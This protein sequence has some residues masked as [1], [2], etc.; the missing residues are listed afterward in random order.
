MK[1]VTSLPSSREILALAFRHRWS[2]ILAF[3][4]PV[5]VGLL[6]PRHLTPK[7]EARAQVLVKPGREFMPQTDTP[8]VSQLPQITMREMVDTVTQILQ[9]ADLIRDVLRDETVGKL[10]PQL[11]E[12]L[13][14]PAARND[15]AAS[16]LAK[17]LAVA[18][19]RL[20]NV[21]EIRLRNADR[22]VAVEAL[23]SVLTRF[24]ERHVQAFSRQRSAL[25]EAQM[26]EN[27]RRLE[28]AYR[29]RAAYVAGRQLFSLPEQRNLLV[30]QRARVSQELRE[31][32][33]RKAMLDEQIRFLA[34]ELA[35]QP[36]T[37]TLQTVS[38]S[39]VVADD[40]RRRLREL[41][42]REREQATRLGPE[43]PALRATRSAIAATQ[44][45][46]AQTSAQSASVAT[47]IN[48]LI[49]TLR[50]QIAAT[51]AERAPL[52]GRIAALRAALQEDDARLR[53]IAEDEIELQTLDRRVSGLES[54]IRELQQRQTD[55]RFSEE[56]DRAQVAGLSV[57]QQ[58]RAPENPVW[59][60]NA[61]FA[62]GGIV[63]GGLLAV[64]RLLLALSFG[65]R[66]LSAETVERMLG[67]PVLAALPPVPALQR[68]KLLL[69]VA[70]EDTPRRIPAAT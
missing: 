39:S 49:T 34:D 41:Q 9:S 54:A 37:I 10:Y 48:P 59:P 40:A 57:I 52:D 25:L 43:H 56:L 35:R 60:K 20:T 50:A 58:P 5:A 44:Q 42:E 61:L 64:L 53:Q 45:A 27:A 11:A 21:I 8:G 69:A 66:F 19:V 67:V 51:E 4:L 47:G 7:Y 62:A 29:E 63:A 65:N 3:L 46:L 15:A 31:T 36:A 28:E 12:Q 14:D 26:V 22:R 1:P 13:A 23:G 17:D 30:Q 33:M 18:P 24:Q 2:L 6:V 16:A 55:A 38:Q 68:R 32:E 70:T